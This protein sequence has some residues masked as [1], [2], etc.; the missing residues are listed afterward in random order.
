MGDSQRLRDSYM[1][2]V[3]NENFDGWNL[4]SSLKTDVDGKP[5]RTQLFC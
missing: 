5:P 2:Y 4:F 3:G 1:K